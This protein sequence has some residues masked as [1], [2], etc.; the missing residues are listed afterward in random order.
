MNVQAKLPFGRPFAENPFEVLLVRPEAVRLSCLL[1]AARPEELRWATRDTATGKQPREKPRA[2]AG[3]EADEQRPFD[4][5]PPFA[6]W[7][8]SLH[9]AASLPCRRKSNV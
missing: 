2:R 7:C 1:F 5:G 6:P 3:H 8:I 4:C 9:E